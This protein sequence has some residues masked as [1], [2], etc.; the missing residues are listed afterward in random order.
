MCFAD[1]HFRRNVRDSLELVT[2]PETVVLEHMLDCYY[3]N[4]VQPLFMDRT[5]LLFCFLLTQIA[6]F[7]VASISGHCCLERT[8]FEGTRPDIDTDAEFPWSIFCCRDA[9]KQACA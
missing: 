4:V 9:R 3:T 5:G 8:M 2:F 6:S 1:A 7:G